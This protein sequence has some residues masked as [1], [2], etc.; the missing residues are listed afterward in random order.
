MG[1]NVVDFDEYCGILDTISIKNNTLDTDKFKYNSPLNTYKS[2]ALYAMIN[3]LQ[4]DEV[5]FEELINHSDLEILF[6]LQGFFVEGT[7]IDRIISQRIEFLQKF[8]NQKAKREEKRSINRKDSFF[9]Y[10]C[11]WIDRKGFKSDSE[12]YN[13]AGISRQMFS[14]IRN[15]KVA[16]SREMALHLAVSL[17]LNYNECTEFLN[18]LGYTLNHNSRR[19]QIMSYIMRKR[20]Y[21]FY[22]MEEILAVFKEKTFLDWD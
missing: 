7:R 3:D 2:F 10:L 16:I 4:E 8:G 22:E 12:F 11:G 9:T 15:N 6:K 1:V 20:K 14:K 17:E 13:A 5:Y 21:T 18:Y 19:E